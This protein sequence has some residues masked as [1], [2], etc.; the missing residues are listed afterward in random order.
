MPARIQDSDPSTLCY[1]SAVHSSRR[2][3]QAPPTAGLKA[4]AGQVSPADGPAYCGTVGGVSV[5]Q[6]G[7]PVGGF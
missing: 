4:G 7:S 3:R 5:L 6:E 1:L 2:V